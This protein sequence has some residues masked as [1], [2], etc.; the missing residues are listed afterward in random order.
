LGKGRVI[1]VSSPT[2]NAGELLAEF[3]ASGRQEAFEEIVRRYAAMVF[4]VCLKTTR[5]A[6][7]AEDATQAVFLTLAVQ[8]KTEK[9]DITYVGPWL[10]K[11][12]R[13]ISLD[14]RRSKKRREV[15]ETNHAT[16]NGN[17][18]G[19]ASGNGHSNG[20]Y[21]D[22]GSAGIDVE[23]LKVVLNEELNQLPAKY[24]LPMIL[25]YYGG[26]TREEIASELGCKPSTLG[27][28]IHRGRQML[29]KR[30]TLRGA[31]PVAMG[32]SLAV[33]LSLAVR[34]TVSDG[35][36]VSTS[37]A[38]AKLMAGEQ[39]GTVIS[40]HVLAV[41][42]GAAGVA[43]LAKLKLV[44]AVVVAAVVLGAGAGAAAKVLPIESLKLQWPISFDGVFRLP[45]FRSPFRAP[46]ANAA[47][48]A[49]GGP[50]R[51]WNDALAAAAR[52]AAE[53]SPVQTVMWVSNDPGSTGNR[54]RPRP[55]AAV[56]SGHRNVGGIA[57]AGRVLAH[58]VTSVVSSHFSKP[59]YASAAP[60][61]VAAPAPPV[62][63]V[64]DR[65]SGA[66]APAQPRP[67]SASGNARAAGG[68]GG[69]VQ[70]DGDV[71]L[72]NSGTLYALRPP[73]GM[74]APTSAG[75]PPLPPSASHNAATPSPVP[76]RTP[77]AVT[78]P[79]LTVAAAPGSRG[80]VTLD[81]GSFAVPNQVIGGRGHGEFRQR[82]GTNTVTNMRLGVDPGSYG[83]Y[84]LEGGVLVFKPG[85]TPT[86]TPSGAPSGGRPRDAAPQVGDTGLEIGDQGTGVFLMGDA[87]GTGA[88]D[89]RSDSPTGSLVVR[90]DPR[91]AG[92]FRGWGGVS[93]NGFFDHNGQAIADGYGVDR[94]LEFT[95]FRYVGNSIENPTA[96]GTSGWF[97][98]DH[99][100]LVLPNIRVR[101]GTGTYTWGEDP[102]DETLDLVNSVRLTLHD[103]DKA[104]L[105]RVSLLSKDNGEV[106]ALPRGHTFI[107][108]WELETGTLQHGDVDITVRYDD[109]MA[110]ELH[111]NEN[112]LKLWRYQDGQWIRM[113]H[114]ASFWR[115]VDQHLLGVTA[116][117]GN[118]EFFAVSAP[119]PS[120][121]SVIALGAAAALLRRRRRSVA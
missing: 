105:M 58:V 120:T 99:G 113:D 56:E 13:R 93:M 18:N 92:T 78:G 74:N 45:S 22:N 98:R 8:C 77:V 106:P 52:T 32:M 63:P 12:A 70:F 46:Q 110:N 23:E 103:V 111:L 28:R 87:S 30:L 37:H 33:G 41:A 115:D 44:A 24:R 71:R 101:P 104:G 64:Q 100:K 94:A 66:A 5:N 114:D 116:P 57:A 20:A 54:P 36:V 2:R 82:G 21:H 27:V 80:S 73:P 81:G 83:E 97:A 86:G 91:G 90:G 59:A 38:A 76:P 85:R 50:G 69:T 47:G 109:G 42:Q 72:S 1:V 35:M 43:M 7:D 68:G 26:L 31:T 108:V 16:A 118:F 84:R 121:V 3:K 55:G 89:T 96:G 49:R 11:V 88:I 17:G 119:E 14:L 39:L 107:G 79:T 75:A 53:A 65:P 48:A 10:Q 67:A 95:G 25:H 61:P 62:A 15:R 34:A 4:G 112:V 117:A 51:S 9:G 29:A 6:H 102:G 60:A 40:S 19:S